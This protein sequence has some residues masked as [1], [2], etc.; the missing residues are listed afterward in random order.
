M[1]KEEYKEL[2]QNCAKILANDEISTDVKENFWGEVEN[3]LFLER[4]NPQHE[5]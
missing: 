1:D 3:L 4:Q 2:I 5:V